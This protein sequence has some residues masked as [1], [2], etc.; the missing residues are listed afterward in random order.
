VTSEIS[1]SESLSSKNDDA[2]KDQKEFEK[3]RNKRKKSDMLQKGTR[4]G[5]DKQPSQL[6]MNVLFSPMPK[7]DDI[8]GHDEELTD[9]EVFYLTEIEQ[10]CNADLMEKL[11]REEKSIRQEILLQK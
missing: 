2:S 5:R 6:E 3:L 7:R 11:Q 9:I 4:R 8:V 10:Q 1:V